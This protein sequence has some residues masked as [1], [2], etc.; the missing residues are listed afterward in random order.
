MAVGAAL[1]SVVTG[2]GVLSSL[3]EGSPATSPTTFASPPVRPAAK[4]TSPAAPG[5]VIDA[6]EIEPPRN[7]RAWQVDH[8]SR[9]A[10]GQDIVVRSLLVVPM[11]EPPPGG[12]P[13]IVWGHSTKGMADTC[14]PSREGA[15]TIPLI[16][17]FVR[18]GY[19]VVA[20]DY[21]GLGAEGPNP[22]LVGPSEGQTMLDSA[23]AAMAV[24]GSGVRDTSAVLLWGF[25]QGGHA[26]AFAGE[27]APTYAPELRLAGVAMAAP[28][29]DVAHF[30]RRS[31]TWP[32]QMGVLVSIAAGFASAY[33][34]LRIEDVLTDEGVADV[35]RL[36]DLC[37]AEVNVL[38][39]RPVEATLRRTPR[40]LP[41][42]QE[43]L[44]ESRAGRRPIGVP[45]LVIQGDADEI[46]DP[47]DTTTLVA[48]YCRQGMDVSYSVRPGENHGVLT[49]DVL[50]PWLRARVAGDRAPSSCL[51]ATPPGTTQ[52]TS[53]GPP[54]GSSGR[55]TPGS[56]PRT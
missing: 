39:D 14:A 37:I 29:S 16:D 23:R 21:E 20:T 6:K 15:P 38:Y 12:F 18:E 36:E 48:N 24:K 43:R 40:E 13:L 4:P 33:P 47:A 41:G 56:G 42:W 52:G 35:G 28:V 26:A 51:E 3:S 50:L 1:A 25:S 8:H 34:E 30:A 17:D 46:I 31:E 32:A 22:Y 44:E 5:T 53:A 19:A 7:A 55:T 27:L 9:G 11:Q 54:E 10:T 49:S 2:C 45:L